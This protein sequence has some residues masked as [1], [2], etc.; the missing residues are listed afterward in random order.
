VKVAANNLLDAFAD[1]DPSKI[2][3]KIKLHIL[4]HLE[5]DIRRHGPLIGSITEV[6]ERFNAIFR[7]CSIF[8]NHLAPG[9]DI[10]QKL[11]RQEVLKHQ[12]MGGW[13]QNSS[14]EWRCAA[15]EIRNVLPSQSIIQNMLGW[16]DLKPLTPGWRYLFTGLGRS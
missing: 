2:T 16:V 1:L 14:G 12:L 5:E 7:Y 8:S 10:S 4:V 15:T 9:R 11:A 3:N 6:F 13:W